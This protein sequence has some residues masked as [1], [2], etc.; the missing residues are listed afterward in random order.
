MTQPL[1]LLHGYHRL[2]RRLAACVRR[3]DAG[4]RVIAPDLRGHGRST[5]PRPTFKFA[6]VA[7][8]MFALP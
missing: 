6:D 2:R 1:L 8:D 5:N 7:R 3:A 4:H